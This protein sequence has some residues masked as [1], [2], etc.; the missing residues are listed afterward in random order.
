M[1][2]IL[3]FRCGQCRAE[4]LAGPGPANHIGRPVYAPPVLCCGETLRLLDTGQV[5]SAPLIPRRVARCPRCG[6]QIR[7]IV[8]P[9]GPLVC[10]PC[11]R[12][13]I[14]IGGNPDR[15]DQ[16]MAPAQRAPEVRK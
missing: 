14:I 8:H 13:L 12:A 15:D 11:Q 2:S 3:G 7:V 9:A 10:V 16:A 4:L 1:G 5:W 6:Y